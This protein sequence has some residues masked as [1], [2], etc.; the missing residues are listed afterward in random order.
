MS[1]MGL[2]ARTLAVRVL[3]VARD[4]ADLSELGVALEGAGATVVRA[5]DL[6]SARQLFTTNAFDS[7][8]VHGREGAP[9]T[10]LLLQ[11]IRSL[12]LGEPRLV[13]VAD[14]EALASLTEAAPIVDATLSSQSGFE[15]IAEAAGLLSPVAPTVMAANDPGDIGVSR[16]RA[17]EDWQG[18]EDRQG[19]T[20]LL[21]CLPPAADWAFLPVG[22]QPMRHPG[23]VPDAVL[24]LDPDCAKDVGEWLSAATA[25]VVPVIDLSGRAPGSGDLDLP[26]RDPRLIAD[27]LRRL[28]PLTERVKQL[29]ARY[30]ATG[31]PRA[32]L[33]A[34]LGVRERALVPVRDGGL[35]T[36]LR[37]PD[38][39]WVPECL[40]AAE[41][42]ARSG[43]LARRFFDR[44]HVCGGCR[45]VRLNVREECFACRSADLVEEP[46]IHHLR[47][48]YQG[49]EHDFGSSSQG[50][51]CP[52]CRLALEHFSVDYDKPGSVFICGACAHVN[53]DAAIGFLC[54]DCETHQDSARIDTRTAY[55]YEL[56]EL[57]HEAFASARIA[58]QPVA[59]SGDGPSVRG[60]LRAFIARQISLRA[61]C[62]IMMVR[63][64]PDGEARRAAGPRLWGQTVALYASLLREVFTAETPILPLNEAWLVL[65]AG[66]SREDV[67]AGLPE[68]R[69]ELEGAIALQLGARYD[70]FGP[71]QLSAF[72]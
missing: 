30:F 1:P 22:T 32:M 10:L 66:E 44:L 26:S 4:A 11:L 67:L 13:L 24:L 18:S 46:V 9:E 37:Y 33:L 41:D 52:K 53:G 35:R 19:S 3:V 14:P 16:T 58:A 36:G 71:D 69:V 57:G 43:H 48:G 38:S 62:A 40:T 54:L 64:D 56:T 49:P 5:V 47:C 8:L 27:G 59:D 34:R 68:L 63:L 55:S 12:A 70:V 31:E 23:R 61:P 42:L 2:T 17:T 72:L 7:I 25:A 15:R 60:A 39:L 20:P 65:L 51:K 50:L 29:P 6:R 28:A 21:L 45:S